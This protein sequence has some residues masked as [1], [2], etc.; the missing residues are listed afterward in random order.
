MP[1]KSKS[2]TTCPAWQ[3]SY[4]NYVGA[5]VAFADAIGLPGKILISSPAE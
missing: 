1:G 3:V 5:W 4:E 2:L